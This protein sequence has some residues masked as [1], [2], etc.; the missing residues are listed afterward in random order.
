MEKPRL[1][2]FGNPIVVARLRIK[3]PTAAA[4]SGD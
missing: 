3:T 2:A 1:P 4:S